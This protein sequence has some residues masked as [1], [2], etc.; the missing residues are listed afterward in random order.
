MVCGANSRCRQCEG[1]GAERAMRR[2]RAGLLRY[3]CTMTTKKK[4]A[5][6]KRRKKKDI[7]VVGRDERNGMLD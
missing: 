3:G 6:K 2:Q 5:L 7:L 1:G 4:S